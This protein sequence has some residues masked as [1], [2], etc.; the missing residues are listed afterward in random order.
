LDELGAVRV[1]RS[2]LSEQSARLTFPSLTNFR[3]ARVYNY[4]R[5]FQHPA[6]VFFDKGMYVCARGEMCLTYAYGSANMNTLEIAS[7]STEPEEGCSFVVSVFEVKGVTYQ[8][9][10][11]REEEFGFVIAD[12]EE[13]RTSRAGRVRMLD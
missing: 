4:R 5:L 8:S 3:L 7:L 12:Y 13:L 1:H 9:F 10:L 2:L 6:A 11:S